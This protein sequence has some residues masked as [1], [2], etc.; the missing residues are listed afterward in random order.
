MHTVLKTGSE[1]SVKLSLAHGYLTA[2]NAASLKPK[3]VLE[4]F[5][6]G[7]IKNPQTSK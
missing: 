1:T 6:L 7:R 5:N 2:W 4:N 3:N